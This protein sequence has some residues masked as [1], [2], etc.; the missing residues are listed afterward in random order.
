MPRWTWTSR[1]CCLGQAVHGSIIR[2]AS[3]LSKVIL[4][5]GPG[6]DELRQYLKLG[7]AQG[8]L[9]EGSLGLASFPKPGSHRWQRI[10]VVSS[11]TSDAT[12]TILSRCRSLPSAEALVMIINYYWHFWY[13]GLVLV[14]SWLSA[15]FVSAV[16][17]S[18]LLFLV[19]GCCLAGLRFGL[20]LGVCGLQFAVCCDCLVFAVCC[21][22]FALFYLLFA[23]CS[24]LL[25]VCDMEP[26]AIVV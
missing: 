8:T 22:L 18:S 21:L 15:G 6:R 5:L 26:W 7:F 17:R 16:G 1:A 10:S 9:L 11:S 14:V 2:T 25:A 13:L 20:R 3:K 23:I 12:C 24:L 19:C 4:C